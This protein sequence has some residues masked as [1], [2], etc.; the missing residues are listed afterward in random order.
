MITD[1]QS[2]L[3]DA[4]ALAATGLSTNT[5]DNVIA[6]NKIS[7]G[8]KM[9]VVITVDVAADLASG[10]E[11][12]QFQLI[13]SANANLSSADVLLETVAAF[14]TKAVLVKGYRL[15]IPIPPGL[16]SKRYLGL[17]YVLGGT[18][19]SITVTSSVIPLS[20]V[21]DEQVYPKNF[22]ITS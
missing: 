1:A 11:T 19:P 17:N 5:L 2:L 22:I 8:E 13:Q 15:V 3:S 16:V 10:D 7:T 14:I 12:Y 21:Q 4:Q 20:F 9:A 6:G 18:T